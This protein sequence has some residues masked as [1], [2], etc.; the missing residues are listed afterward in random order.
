MVTLGA[1]GASDANRTLRA[2]VALVTPG[3]RS[4]D[5]ARRSVATIAAIFAR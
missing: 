2:S 4:T 1:T 3:T 5:F